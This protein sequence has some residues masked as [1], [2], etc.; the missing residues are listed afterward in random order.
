VLAVE[1][2][3]HRRDALDREIADGRADQLVLG[4]EI[5]VHAVGSVVVVRTSARRERRTRAEEHLIFSLLLPIFH[6][7]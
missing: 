3:R 1:L 4:R 5:E 6:P 7:S 2:L